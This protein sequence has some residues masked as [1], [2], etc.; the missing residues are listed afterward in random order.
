MYSLLWDQKLVS[1]NSPSTADASRTAWDMA[2]DVSCESEAALPLEGAALRIHIQLAELLG[3]TKEQAPTL[4]LCAQAVAAHAIEPDAMTAYLKQLA[5]MAKLSSRDGEIRAENLGALARQYS[6]LAY[7]N[8]AV[9]SLHEWR[10]RFSITEQS[11]AEPR[12]SRG[13]LLLPNR[14]QASLRDFNDFDGRLSG[15]LCQPKHEP[16]SPEEFRI[17]VR[18][19]GDLLQACH[20]SKKSKLW[21][22]CRNA[23]LHPENW[24]QSIESMRA[25]TALIPACEGYSEEITKRVFDLASCYSRGHPLSKEQAL[26]LAERLGSALVAGHPEVAMV[27]SGGNIHG[28]GWGDYGAADFIVASYCLPTSPLTIATLRSAAR[29]VP[30]T[31]LARMEQNRIDA[32]G[33]HLGGYRDLVHDQRPLVHEITVAMV[34]YYDA[35]KISPEAKEHAERNLRSIVALSDE[36]YLNSER[37]LK[38]I[39]DLSLYEAKNTD[40]QCPQGISTIERLRRIEGNTSPRMISIPVS[41]DPEW[42]ELVSGVVDSLQEGSRDA[43]AASLAKLNDTLEQECLVASPTLTPNRILSMSALE[44][45]LFRELQSIG[46]EDQLSLLRSPWFHQILRFQELTASPDPFSRDRFEMLI[47]EISSAP[48][49][50][51]AYQEVFD[52]CLRGR[53]GPLAT[54]YRADNHPEWVGALWSGNIDHELT[55]LASWRPASTAVGRRLRSELVIPPWERSTGD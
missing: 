26:I 13:R 8:A 52:R 29:A 39:L 10:G 12:N 55:T 9:E 4:E 20:S 49:F 42:N 1:T 25:L 22:E 14:A 38:L 46:F 21:R 41:Q 11:L 28:M 48:S 31:D 6:S 3:A 19:Y 51:E 32:L 40:S 15:Q 7:L 33:C 16:P 44:Q 36:K 27:Q 50:K 37:G 43:L 24:G 17:L 53:V 30:T 23:Y 47:N 5:T 34:R 45:L 18:A 2:I 54:H 35:S